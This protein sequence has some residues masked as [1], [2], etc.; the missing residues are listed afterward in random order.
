MLNTPH[1]KIKIP[2]KHRQNKNFIETETMVL[3][4]ESD[5]DLGEK[6]S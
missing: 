6:I 3:G 4:E 1:P 5:Y 2:T